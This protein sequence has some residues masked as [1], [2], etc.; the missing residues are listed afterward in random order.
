MKK[1]TSVFLNHIL[2]SIEWIEKDIAGLS[3]KE[4]FENVPIQDAV[5]RRLEIIGEA[6]R[7]LNIDFRQNYPD[8][9]WKKIAGMRDKLIH[10]YFDVDLE[11][12]WEVVKKDMP[13]LYKYIQKINKDL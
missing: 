3:R 10:D 4:F 8:V 2:D 11:L 9:P 12:V 5:F 7:N 1:D 13:E 6:T